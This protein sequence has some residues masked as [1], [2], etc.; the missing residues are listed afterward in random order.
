MSK[1]IPDYKRERCK[2][3]NFYT[4]LKRLQI[5]GY[6]LHWASICKSCGNV[7]IKGSTKSSQ[8]IMEIKR[9][10]IEKEILGV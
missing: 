7:I 6:P 10:I 5:W 2:N 1:M 4:T 3:C 9:K 8:Q